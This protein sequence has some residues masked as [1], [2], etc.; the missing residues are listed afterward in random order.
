MSQRFE[1]TRLGSRSYRDVIIKKIDPRGKPYYWIAGQPEKWS[2]GE[3]SDFA[4]IERGN[5]SVTPLH[6]DMTALHVFEDIESWK[7]DD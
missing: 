7:F 4:A 5:I 1:I 3:H 2:G 6:L